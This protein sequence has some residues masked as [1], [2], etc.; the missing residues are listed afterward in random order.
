MTDPF[1]PFE[2]RMRGAGC[3]PAAIESF[4]HYYAELRAGQTGMLSRREIGPVSDVPRAD[5]LARHRAAGLASFDRTVVVKLN[6]GLGTS[7]GMTKAKSL[8]PVKGDQT[9]LDV[10]ARQVLHLRRA[11]RCRLPLVL[12][13]SFRTQADSLAALARHPEL[14]S[15]VPADFLQNKVPK[16]RADDLSPVEWPADPDHEWCPPGHG[17]LYVALVSSGML[18]KLLAAGYRYA[19]VSNADNLGAVPDPGILGWLA[20]EEIPFLMEVCPRTEAHKKGGHLAARRGGGLALRESAQCPDDEKDEFQDVRLYRFFNTNNLWLDLVALDAALRAR[21]GVLG[22][23]MIRNVKTVDP[24]D[25]ASPKVIQ[26]ETA[27]GAAIEVFPGARAVC[28]PEERFAPV[29]TTN[30]LLAVWSDAYALREDWTLAPA[31]DPA[32]G[33]LVVDLDPAFYQRIDQLEARFPHGA[34]SLVRCRR[35]RVRGDVRFGRGVVAEGEVEVRQAGPA[36]L[37]IPD[38]RALRGALEA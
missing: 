8:L 23:P 17:D 11:H 25:P 5:D 13:N 7:M 4:R 3:P 38:G 10:I 20:E 36:P 15:D 30:D 31:R 1:A 12:M 34:P 32:L 24:A 33:T 28:V 6:G 14:A 22:L 26:L 19:F 37:E 35:F 2:A 18:E 21:H 27:M 9:F 16:V 29:K